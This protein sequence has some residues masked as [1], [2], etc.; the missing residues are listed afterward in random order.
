R[1][2]IRAATVVGGVVA[3]DHTILQRGQ[4]G[5]AAVGGRNVSVQGAVIQDSTGR[6]AAEL[7]QVS[8]QD[9]VGDDA[10]GSPIDAAGFGIITD[11]TGAVGEGEAGECGVGVQKDA[12]DRVGS[13]GVGAWD[14]RHRGAVDAAQRDE[15]GD[16]DAV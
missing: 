6:T 3:S 12:T 13:G 7:G 9:A 14:H 16:G 10:R 15:I 4:V 2:G 1:T 11:A 8:R 5:A